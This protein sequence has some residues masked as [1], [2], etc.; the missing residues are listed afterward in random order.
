MQRV[1]KETQ[2]AADAARS[3]ADARVTATTLPAGSA[4]T[5]TRTTGEDGV[6]EIAY[7]IPRGEPGADGKPG[8]DGAPGPIGPQG[9]QGPAGEG[10]KILGLYSTF[11]A[12]QAA[13][14]TGSAGDAYAVGTSEDNEIYIWDVDGGAWKNLGALQGPPG[15]QGEQGPEGKQ[16]PQGP[17][18]ADGAQGPEGPQGKQGPAGADGEQ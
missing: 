17:A 12:L 5:V 15:P 13:H 7:G 9:P 11:A 2:E 1:T 10:L 6:Q 3:F 14:P 8:Q 18:G 4:A 16:G